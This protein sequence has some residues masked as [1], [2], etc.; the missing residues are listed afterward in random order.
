MECSPGCFVF[1]SLNP[2]PPVRCRIFLELSVNRSC[3]VEMQ[4]YGHCFPPNEAPQPYDLEQGE[5]TRCVACHRSGSFSCGECAIEAVGHTKTYYCS[6]ACQNNHSQRHGPK[7]L[8]L[9]SLSR[10]VRVLDEIW[11]AFEEAT[12]VGNLQYSHVDG[13]EVVLE[14]TSIE[15]RR[16]QALTGQSVLESFYRLPNS[17]QPWDVRGLF[18]YHGK[19][20]EPITT[21]QPLL[22][23]ILGRVGQ[24]HQVNII[25]KNLR[26]KARVLS[27]DDSSAT[28]DEIDHSII[29]IK[30]HGVSSSFVLDLTGAQFGWTERL[31][32]WQSYCNMRLGTRGTINTIDNDRRNAVYQQEAGFA[33][34]SIQR[35]SRQLREVVV[36]KMAISLADFLKM[37]NSTMNGLL[38]LPEDHYLQPCRE[39]VQTVID[40][41]RRELDGIHQQG[42]GR[43][44]IRGRS[45]R[46][47][48]DQDTA[49]KCSKLWITKEDWNSMNHQERPDLFGRWGSAFPG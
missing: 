42:R 33:P 48:I 5:D 1:P 11:G 22:K 30:P 39:L 24:L 14:E 44:F 15:H 16:C 8:A 34:D 27:S 32:T 31:Y 4:A 19:A 13:S 35:A 17:N 38:A 12:F 2:L 46:V 47:V 29:L 3:L 26:A 9:R 41:A 20:K 25:I 7:C 23:L 40:C 49:E 28:D 10:S 43:L 45:V 37:R 21:G 18:L 6:K 36:A